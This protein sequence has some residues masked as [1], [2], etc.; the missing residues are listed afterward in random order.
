M[1]KTLILSMLMGG[2]LTTGALAQK[3]F[4]IGMSQCNLG[5]P[6]RVQMNADI[7]KSGASRVEANL[8]GCPERYA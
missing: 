5:E 7:K 6:W 4:T 2:M 3:S 1:Q 8:Q